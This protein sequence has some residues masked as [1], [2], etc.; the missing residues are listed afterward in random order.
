MTREGRLFDEPSTRLT[1]ALVAL[2]LPAVVPHRSRYASAAVAAVAAVA[3][4]AAAP[5]ELLDVPSTHA[6]VEPQQ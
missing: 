5:V 3:A 1:P 2:P 4:A 6:R